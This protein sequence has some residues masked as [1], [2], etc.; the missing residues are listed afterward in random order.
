MRRKSPLLNKHRHRN[1]TLK[2][3]TFLS[4]LEI[5]V[6]LDMIL[7]YLLCFS[8]VCFF[9]KNILLGLW[10]YTVV[11]VINLLQSIFYLCR[12]SHGRKSWNA[13]E[14]WLFPLL[15]F[16]YSQDLDNCWVLFLGT[17]FTTI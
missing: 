16:G 17:Q 1:P 9:F 12:R 15:S 4:A 13:E 10:A 8:F 7:F 14:G 5:L 11:Y 3:T 6:G 2:C